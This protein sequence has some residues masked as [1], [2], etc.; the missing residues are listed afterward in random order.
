MEPHVMDAHLDETP[1]PRFG[2]QLVD[3]ALAHAGGDANQ[4]PMAPALLEPRERLVEDV[5]SAAPLVAHDL[6][7]LDADERRDVAEPPE[8]AR[9]LV[10]DELTVREDLEVAVWMRSEELQQLGMRERLAPEDAEVTVTVLL[11]VAD[12]AAE[13]LERD[14]LRRRL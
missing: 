13:I 1:Q 12:D 2:H 14:S 5:Q 8:L 4:Q 3:V 11:G 9:H 10:G 7:P 6:G